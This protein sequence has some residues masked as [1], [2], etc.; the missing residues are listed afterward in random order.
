MKIEDF[1]S[2]QDVINIYNDEAIKND[3]DLLMMLEV[4]KFL[5]RSAIISRLNQLRGDGQDTVFDLKSVARKEITRGVE[6][7]FDV[8]ISHVNRNNITIVYDVTKK[9]YKDSIELSLS[10][11]GGITYVAVTPFNFKELKGETEDCLEYDSGI[12]FKRILLEALKLKATDIHFCVEHEDLKARYPVKYRKNGLLYEMKLFKLDEQTNKAIISRLIDLKTA[13]NSLDLTT[14]AGVTTIS[15]DPLNNGELEL[16]IAANKVKDGWHCVIR[17]Q[18]KSTFSFSI[19]NLGFPTDVQEMLTDLTERTSGI[20]FITG[21]IRTG[22]N[23]TAFA[24]INE[25]AKHP[26]KIVSYE[27]PV[28]VEMPFTQ[29]DYGDDL[30]TLI[31][32]VRLAKK[33]DV[34]VAYLN[35]LPNKEVAFAVQD[36]VNSS[37]YV[38]TTMHVDRIWHLPY[39]LKEYYGESYKDVISQITAVVNQKMF[40]VACPECIEHK[41]VGDLKPSLARF[42]RKHGVET[43]AVNRGCDLCHG[44]GMIDGANQPYVEYLVFTPELKDELLKC[45]QPYEMESVLRKTIEAQRGSLEY[46]MLDGVK[47]EKLQVGAINSIL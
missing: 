30:E 32:A 21:A 22:K 29:V 7:Q 46:R 5:P 12:L 38:I 40:G 41:L 44:T 47:N 36:L 23:T 42:F 37:V 18:T 14:P 43:V 34:N 1:T 19:E 26:V 24:M 3:Y 31:N 4:Y 11:Y 25:I 28:E 13:A 8:L 20:V 33:Q 27:S 15:D 2:S 10:E 45:T 35:E 17:I 16:R 6:V 39:K 9:I